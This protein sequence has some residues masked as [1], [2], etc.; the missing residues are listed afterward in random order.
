MGYGRGWRRHLPLNQVSDR[1]NGAHDGQAKQ[2]V[3]GSAASVDDLLGVLL[4]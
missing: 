4:A 1:L 2:C 3:I